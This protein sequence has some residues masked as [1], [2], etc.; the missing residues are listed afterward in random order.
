MA[1]TTYTFGFDPGD[2]ANREDLVDLVSIITPSETPLVS[3]AP[4]VKA[5]HVRHDWLA[6]RL[7]AT[8]TAGAVEGADFASA[9][10]L[11][12]TRLY[13]VSQIYKEGVKVSNTQ[14]AVHPAGFRDTYKREVSK[15][16]REIARNF[17]R[18][19][20]AASGQSASGNATTARQMRRLKDYI[21][22]HQRSV[23]AWNS[24]VTGVATASA[25]MI[26]ELG[27]NNLMQDMHYDGANPDSIHASGPAKR[28]LSM[29]LQGPSQARRTIPLVDKRMSVEVALYETDFGA[30]DISLNRWV[31]R[32]A[33]TV[34][35]DNSDLSGDVFV[36]ER[37]LVRV[38]TLRPF[39]YNP[40]ASPGDSTRGEVV[41]E[42]CIEVLNP[43][44]CGRMWGVNN[45]ITA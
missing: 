45:R 24:G 41:G 4:R 18:T 6:D 20:F 9:S 15:A 10:A 13:N 44:G 23:Q 40:L 11:A 33:N 38:A 31:S 16:A 42:A 8:A 34:A 32:S 7:R 19:I 28:Q 35:T 14:R 27:L 21:S 3:T 17:E 37:A 26:T 5:T 1:D 12:P 29:A 43:T 22:K 36:L 39:Q 25:A 2:G 30:V